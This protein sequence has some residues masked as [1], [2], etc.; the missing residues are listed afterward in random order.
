MEKKRLGDFCFEGS[1]DEDGNIGPADGVCKAPQVPPGHYR[2]ILEFIKGPDLDIRSC[3]F[4]GGAGGLIEGETSFEVYCSDCGAR[5]P[6]FG[7]VPKDKLYRW[8]A[9]KDA[10]AEWNRRVR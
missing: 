9:K 1:I 2:I 5:G 6:R 7:A 4:C 8:F 10:I 3:P